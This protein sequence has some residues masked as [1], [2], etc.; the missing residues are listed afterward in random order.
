MP[1]R[2]KLRFSCGATGYR[3]IPIR[4]GCANFPSQGVRVALDLKVVC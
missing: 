4:Y 1:G 3:V 2:F